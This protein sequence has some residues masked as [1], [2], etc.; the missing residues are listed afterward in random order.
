MLTSSGKAVAAKLENGGTE[1]KYHHFSIVMHRKRRLAIFTS[2]N[3]D[4]RNAVRLIDGRKPSRRE[5]TELDPNAQEK[6]VTDPRIPDANQLPDV[7]YTK[8]GGAFDKGHLIRRDD[9]AWGAT[10]ADMQM[11]NGDTYHTTNCSPQVAGFNRSASEDNWGDLEVLVQKETKSERVCIFAGPVLQ[12]DDLVFRGR[13]GRGPTELQI[14]RKYWKIIVAI[15]DD[16]PR[17]FGFVLEQD[18]SDVPLEFAVPMPWKRYM[19]SISEIGGM[20]NGWVKLTWL[21]ERDGFETEEGRR[22]ATGARA[23]GRR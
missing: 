22:V 17:A 14:P 7:F 10:F 15:G 13:D 4:W 8:D 1:L 23:A 9:V 16:G 18:L 12:D 5:L 2:S 20:L 3:V 6:W 21:K 11:A 19:Q